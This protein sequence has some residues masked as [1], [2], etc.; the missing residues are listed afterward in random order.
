VTGASL[1]RQVEY[2]MDEGYGTEAIARLLGV[3]A[4]TA[5]TLM[6]EV[7]VM[8]QRRDAECDPEM[9]ALDRRIREEASAHPV[10]TWRLRPLDLSLLGQGWRLLKRWGEAPIVLP[11]AEE[12]E[13]HDVR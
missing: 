9:A 8:R 5:D 1:F 11:P 13:M 7:R 2:L 10:R 6:A 12:E 3:T 4:G